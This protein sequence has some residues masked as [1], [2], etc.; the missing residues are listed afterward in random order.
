MRRR[1]A[2]KATGTSILA[3]T[4]LT[5]STAAEDADDG[6]SFG[7]GSDDPEIVSVESE[8]ARPDEAP[9]NDQYTVEYGSD[10]VVEISGWVTAPTTCYHVEVDGVTG[11]RHGDVVDLQLVEESGG[12]Y[13]VLTDIRYSVV[14]EYDDDAADVLVDVPNGAGS[15]GPG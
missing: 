10:G 13:F 7:W 4:A 12:C 5:A 15:E 2:L 6:W 8:Q 14:L 11:S 1:T 3:G 9:E